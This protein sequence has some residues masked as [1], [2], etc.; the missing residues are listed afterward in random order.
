MIFNYL[1]LNSST[2][3]DLSNSASGRH[4]ILFVFLVSEKTEP[5]YFQSA[6]MQW[7]WGESRFA[8]TALFRP[9]PCSIARLLACFICKHTYKTI[10]DASKT[11]NKQWAS[12]NST[13]F[14]KT[15]VPDCHTLSICGLNI[16]PHACEGGNTR[17]SS[18]SSRAPRAF[19]CAR[20]N[21]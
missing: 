11:R 9:A 15:F 18:S 8:A 6:G 21:S 1:S 2:T 12:E 13:A 7:K 16:P 10:K 17:A 14:K 3:F 4:F 5:Q 20:H 19:L